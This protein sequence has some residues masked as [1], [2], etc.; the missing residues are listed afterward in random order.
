MDLSVRPG[1]QQRQA[2]LAGPHR[3][4]L[5][6]HADAVNQE[7][8]SVRD[9]VDT[10][11]YGTALAARVRYPYCTLRLHIQLMHV[12]GEKD[13]KRLRRFHAGRAYNEKQPDHEAES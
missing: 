2:L 6:R 13:A 10:R 1:Q 5:M 8:L 9:N 4:P 12:C 7:A 3:Q 11:V